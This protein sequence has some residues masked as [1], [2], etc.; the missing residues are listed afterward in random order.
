MRREPEPIRHRAITGHKTS[1]HL[2]DQRGE[3]RPV[4]GT[5]RADHDWSDSIEQ[6]VLAG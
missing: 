6:E 3:L 1:D 4:P 5:R 2:A